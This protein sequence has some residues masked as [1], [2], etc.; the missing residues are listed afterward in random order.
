MEPSAIEHR[1]AKVIGLVSCGHFFSHF[2]GLAIPPLIPVLRLEFD[3]S[4]AQLGL[5]VSAMSLASGVA[6]IP[7]GFLVDRLGP[8]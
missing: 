3:A 4:Y 6:Q 8:S 5:L 7:V 1:E 2:Y